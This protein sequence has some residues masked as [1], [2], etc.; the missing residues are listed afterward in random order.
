M[1]DLLIHD[2]SPEDDRLLKQ[3]SD[4]MERSVQAEVREILTNAAHAADVA[5]ARTRTD[6]IRASIVGPIRYDSA[7]L[8]R[9]F[10]DR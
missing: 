4:A 2:L 6:T 7:D 5:S 3:R 9:E 10:R 8:V 1:P